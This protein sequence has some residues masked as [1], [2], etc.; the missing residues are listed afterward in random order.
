MEPKLIAKL[1]SEDPDIIS[2]DIDT[3]KYTGIDIVRKWIY[4]QMPPDKTPNT[5]P[6]KKAW[7]KMASNKSGANLVKFVMRFKGP[8]WTRKNPQ[9]FER[10]VD[11][12]S[13]DDSQIRS[14]N[15][16]SRFR[17]R[18]LRIANES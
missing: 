16:Y 6:W 4:N 3:N 2:E 18:L 12:I 5:S 10:V 13:R 8:A 7:E 14:P 11:Y 9:A 17:D 1:I 15:D